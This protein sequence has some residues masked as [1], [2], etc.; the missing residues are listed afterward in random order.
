MNE[1]LRSSL[2]QSGSQL[3]WQRRA[4]VTFYCAAVPLVLLALFFIVVVCQTWAQRDTGVMEGPEPTDT[5][6]IACT[7][8]LGLFTVIYLLTFFLSHRITATR[9]SWLPFAIQ[10]PA[11]LWL[12]IL[13]LQW[14]SDSVE[15]RLWFSLYPA[16]LL[17][18]LGFGTLTSLRL[19][20][21]NRNA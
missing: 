14:S 3:G 15:E 16:L 19:Y 7:V 12:V 18:I 10:I 8:S 9:L 4:Y 13:R 1:A 6:V 20:A 17:T 2:P 5:E 11:L 21:G